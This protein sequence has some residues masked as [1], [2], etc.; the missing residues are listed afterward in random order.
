MRR[1]L[2]DLVVLTIVLTI[3]FRLSTYV[4]FNFRWVGGLA[5]LTVPACI[6]GEL[7][8]RR[9]GR[10]VTSAFAWQVAFVGAA[11]LTI[12][13]I[14]N[15]VVLSGSLYLFGPGMLLSFTFVMFIISFLGIR[16][17]FRWGVKFGVRKSPRPIDPEIFG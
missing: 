2:I 14:L 9:T 3:F 4:G 13:H 1:I 16:L 5:L 8:G 10:E 11:A 6:A 15:T 12:L 17:V 7:Y